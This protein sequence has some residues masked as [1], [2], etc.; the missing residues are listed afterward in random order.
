[1]SRSSEYEKLRKIWYKKLERSG[2]NDIEL[3]DNDLKE[4]S[5]IFRLSRNPQVVWKAKV[6]YY[7]MATRFL[8]DYEFKSKQDKIIW[9]YHTEGLACRNIA[10]LLTKALRKKINHVVVWR[11]VSKHRVIMKTMYSSSND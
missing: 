1:M 2:F 10:K 7:H 3:N 9:E 5:S 8:N 11:T 6:A 4:P